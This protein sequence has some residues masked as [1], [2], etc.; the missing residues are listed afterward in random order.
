MHLVFTVRLGKQ[1]LIDRTDHC[2]G[3]VRALDEEF[4]GAGVRVVEE[5]LADGG[6]AIASGAAGFLIVGLHAAGH[7]VVND[8]AHVRAVDAH[9][10]GVGGHGDIRLALNE[11]F[12][13]ADAVL[14][15]HAT[16]VGHAFKAPAGDG[17]GNGLHFLAGGAIDDA[18][19]VR[20]DHGLH[21]LVLMHGFFHRGDRE[22]EIRTGESADL[23]EGFAQAEHRGDVL[24]HDRRGGGC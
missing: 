21:P 11:N 7:L 6:L 12:L 5:Q 8:E 23:F 13:G 20:G 9:A 16:V 2:G 17:F 4:L 3:R 22:R 15:A 24:A 18:G 14:I 19:L 1:I 10:E